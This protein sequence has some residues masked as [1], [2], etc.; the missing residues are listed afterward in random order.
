[1]KIELLKENKIRNDMYIFKLLI[2]C[3]FEKSNSEVFKLLFYFFIYVV[4]FMILDKYIYVCI[5][6]FMNV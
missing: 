1:M 6:S 5:C 3:F 4:F 2:N